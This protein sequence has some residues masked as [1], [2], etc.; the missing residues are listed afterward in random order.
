MNFT[1]GVDGDHN[2]GKLSLNKYIYIYVYIY[3]Y[4]YIFINCIFWHRAAESLR[5]LFSYS[6]KLKGKN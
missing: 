5:P 6:K 2:G 4:I 1:R 3:I